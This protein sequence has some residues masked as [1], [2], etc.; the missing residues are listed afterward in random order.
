M[1]EQVSAGVGN[2]KYAAIAVNQ[3]MLPVFLGLLLVTSLAWIFVS[4]RLYTV[5]RQNHPELYAKLG[6]PKLIMPKSIST[7]FKIVGFLLRHQYENIA[8]QKVKQLC[9]GLRA[10]LYIYAVCLGGCLLIWLGTAGK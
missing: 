3:Q 4:G 5:L 7:N 6:R 1:T 8:D 10:L 9:D 2:I